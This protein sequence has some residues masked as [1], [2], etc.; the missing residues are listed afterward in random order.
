MEAKKSQKHH[1]HPSKKELEHRVEELEK[2]LE[3]KSKLA[4]EYLDHLQR[5]KAEFENYKKRSAKNLDEYKKFAKGDIIH[6]LLFV[7]DDF[8]RALG[9]PNIQ[10]TVEHFYKGIEIIYKSLLDTLSKEGVKLIE[11]KDKDFDPQFHEAMQTVEIEEGEDGKV[12]EELQKGY[13]IHDKLLRPAKV[14]VSKLKEE[15]K[16]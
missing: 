15:E 2:L 4:D 13:M 16:E 9:S 10:D 6:N 1:K 8:E 12:L 3:E 11:T 5:F 14:K 7:I